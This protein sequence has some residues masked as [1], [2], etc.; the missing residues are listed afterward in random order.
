MSNIGYV[1]T[2]VRVPALDLRLGRDLTDLMIK[3]VARLRGGRSQLPHI[4]ALLEREFAPD[5]PADIG[6]KHPL[7]VLLAQAE[8]VV[9]QNGWTLLTNA[10]RHIQTA[11]PGETPKKHKVRNWQQVFR[12][13]Q[14]FEVRKDLSSDRL[15]IALW[16]RS[17]PQTAHRLQ[18]AP[19]TSSTLIAAPATGNTSQVC[20]TG[21]PLTASTACA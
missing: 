10:I 20:S 18:L 11:A 3:T 6:P 1:D 17:P 2:K 21:S 13:S 7:V 5:P 12:R 15:D 19:P 16:Y 4:Q 14:V 8:A 9:G